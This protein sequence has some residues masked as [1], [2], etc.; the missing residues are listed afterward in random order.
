M[1]DRVACKNCGDPIVFAEP[2]FTNPRGEWW[3]ETVD[4]DGDVEHFKQCFRFASPK[5]DQRVAAEWVRLRAEWPTLPAPK[6][7][8]K[9]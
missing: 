7:V 3:H 6:E 9:P 2:T 5:G 1:G 4:D 8:Q